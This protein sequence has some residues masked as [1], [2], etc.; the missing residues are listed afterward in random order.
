MTSKSKEAGPESAE[1]LDME[2]GIYSGS[3]REMQDNTLTRLIQYEDN[4]SLSYRADP[5]EESPPTQELS[6]NIRIRDI[7]YRDKE[8]GGENMNIYR[9]TPQVNSKS[10]NPK[11]QIPP[12]NN[13]NIHTLLCSHSIPVLPKV[14]AVSIM[15]ETITSSIK[16]CEKEKERGDKNT[17]GTYMVIQGDKHFYKG[18]SQ[19]NDERANFLVTQHE[20][21]EGSHRYRECSFQ[22]YVSHRSKYLGDKRIRDLSSD[23]ELQHSNSSMTTTRPKCFSA[24][25]S[26]RHLEY[27]VGS[28]L[29]TKNIEDYMKP[30]IINSRYLPVDSGRLSPVPSNSQLW[31]TSIQSA[32]GAHRIKLSIELIEQL[33]E[34]I[35]RRL[36]AQEQGGL[37][38]R[39]LTN[40]FEE[41]GIFTCQHLLLGGGSSSR[42]FPQA[43]HI[44]KQIDAE[45]LFLQQFWIRFN[46]RNL[47]L[48]ENGVIY[49]ALL[50]LMSTLDLPTKTTTRMLTGRNTS[51]K[52]VFIYY[53][54][55]GKE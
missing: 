16:K 18:G 46:P 41:L 15:R 8:K 30:D 45:V 21:I 13:K 17:G 55:C 12:A 39:G 23:V 22:P 37:N 31:I 4:S 35:I 5:H 26:A 38:Y 44:L 50:V 27:G 47:D 42:V 43:G 24:N 20:G 1:D 40:L 36:D 9:V 32:S 53:R 6:P 14:N 19:H 52:Y 54:I 48:M 3:R 49:D 25:S 10:P 2:G 28:H 33:L 34:T 7:E 29:N 11:S 51:S